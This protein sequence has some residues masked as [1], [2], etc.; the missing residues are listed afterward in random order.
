MYVTF[1]Y[2]SQHGAY[3]EQA[4]LDV[5][6]KRSE[7]ALTSPLTVCQTSLLSEEEDTGLPASSSLP[8]PPPP[9]SSPPECGNNHC[10]LARVANCH[11]VAI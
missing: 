5:C 9:P 11:L 2:A 6:S 7:P 3:T 1:G 10:D 4:G 8:L